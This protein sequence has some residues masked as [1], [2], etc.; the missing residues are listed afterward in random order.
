MDTARSKRKHKLHRSRVIHTDKVSLVD[1]VDQAIISSRRVGTQRALERLFAGVLQVVSLDRAKVPRPVA[2]YSAKR[3]E[4]RPP[5]S[6][7]LHPAFE[8][9]RHPLRTLLY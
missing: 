7:A 3:R 5:R 9:A 2:A 8:D 1:M 4:D 6:E